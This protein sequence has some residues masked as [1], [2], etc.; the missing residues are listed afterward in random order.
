MTAQPLQGMK[1]VTVALNVPGP[2]AA[3]RLVELGI[4]ATK[5]EPPAGDPLKLIARRWYD[6]LTQAQSVV[7]LD[8]KKNL[9]RD[10]LDEFLTGADLLLTS[11]R[12]SALQRLR[13]DWRSVHPR[14]PRLCAVNIIGHPPP[15][16]EVPGHDL[17]YQAKLGLLRPPQLPVTLYVDLAGAERAVSVSLALLLNRTRT[18]QAEFAPVSLYE[19]ARDV[20]GPLTAGLTLPTGMLGGAFPLYGLYETKD[21]WIAVAALEPAFMNR[22][23]S[24]LNLSNLTHA[25][26]ERIFRGRD[27]AEWEQWARERDLPIAAL[28]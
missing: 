14:H 16:E 13:L 10:K 22:M 25:Q 2:V 5:I 7:A 17:T 15:D 1:L 11:F 21:R 3:A 6:L 18:G 23:K 27:A 12:P 9:D 26:L 20:A 19:A 8:L 24:E 4:Q 28:A